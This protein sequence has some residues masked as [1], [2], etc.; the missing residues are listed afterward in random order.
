MDLD[1][2]DNNMYNFKETPIYA[3]FTIN[4]ATYTS[5]E[6]HDIYKSDVDIYSNK[7]DQI[8]DISR[9][10]NNIID[11]YQHMEFDFR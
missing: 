11:K 3:Y 9:G 7:K 2:Y 4:Q 1:L 8:F 10:Y 6:N 5:K